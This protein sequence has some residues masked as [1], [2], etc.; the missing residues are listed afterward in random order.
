MT[1]R[2][3]QLVAL[4]SSDDAIKIIIIWGYPLNYAVNLCMQIFMRKIA[5]NDVMTVM[6]N[7]NLAL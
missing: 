7:G 1:L 6:A 5:L 2:R 4:T 3:C